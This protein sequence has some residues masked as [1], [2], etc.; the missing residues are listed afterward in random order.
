[1]SASRRRERHFAPID[2]GRR[3][4]DLRY[5]FGTALQHAPSSRPRPMPARSPLILRLRALERLAY[6]P[7]WGEV[8]ESPSALLRDAVG[9]NTVAS[10]DTPSAVPSPRLPRPSNPTHAGSA[11]RR[12][13][14]DC[15]MQRNTAELPF[16][17]RPMASRPSRGVYPAPWMGPKGETVLL[18][19]TADGRLATPGPVVVPHG[20]SRIQ[21]AEELWDLL[22][23]TDPPRRPTIRAL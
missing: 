9:D 23:R 4:P 2:S 20:A 13:R 18:P 5:P 21:A 22:D 17:P 12:G 16:H 8:R 7:A 19:I 11:K 1:M 10:A 15:R 6:S 14:G 3:Y